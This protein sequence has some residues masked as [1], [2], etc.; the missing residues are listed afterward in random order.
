[1]LIPITIYRG[2]TW[3]LPHGAMDLNGTYLPN[4]PEI[5][6]AN[7]FVT[8]TVDCDGRLPSSTVTTLPLIS[9]TF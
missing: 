5:T 4:C 6:G 2:G 9:P 7:P 8:N 1:M 3:V